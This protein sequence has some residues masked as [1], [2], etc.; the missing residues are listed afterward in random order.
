MQ[1]VV[2]TGQMPIQIIML[3]NPKAFFVSPLPIIVDRRF[4]KK[5]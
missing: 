3:Q 1:Q 5:K 2:I 4:G